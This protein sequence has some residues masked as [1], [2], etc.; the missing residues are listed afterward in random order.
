LREEILEVAQRLFIQHGYHGLSMR[1]IADEVGVTKA[2]L[3]YHFTD[4]Q[5]LFLEILM[6]YLDE[7]GE[8]LDIVRTTSPKAADRLS[9]FVLGV[10]LQPPEQRALIR[11]A[12]QEISELDPQLRKTFEVN[13]HLQ[14]IDRIKDILEDGIKAGEFKPLDSTLATWALLGMMYPYFYPA[15]ERTAPDPGD[16]A[17]SLMGIYLNGIKA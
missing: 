2:A 11:L 10:L 15:H 3:Y 6:G 17:E 12:S 13:Y 14:F 9:L 4:K 16:L 1:Q 8:L 5:Q 7:V